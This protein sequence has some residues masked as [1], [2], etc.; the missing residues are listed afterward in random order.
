MKT[1]VSKQKSCRLTSKSKVV[2]DRL[3]ERSKSLGKKLTYPEIVAVAL[4]LVKDEHLEP[5]IKKRQKGK[6]KT[7]ILTDLW[8]KKNPKKTIDD[9]ENFKLT[10]GWIEFVNEHNHLIEV[11]S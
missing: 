9:A 4:N 7:K 10:I 2:I 3:Q 6:D 11:T 1:N 8:L 5:E